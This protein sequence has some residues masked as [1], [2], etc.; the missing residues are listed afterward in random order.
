MV[1]Q[2]LCAPNELSLVS[3]KILDPGPVPEAT[4]P[5]PPFLPHVR[6]DLGES[7]ERRLQSLARREAWP[8]HKPL[9]LLPPPAAL[10]DPGS[11]TSGP[12][13]PHPLALEAMAWYLSPDFLVYK[14]RR[15]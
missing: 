9:P 7:G 13:P 14:T 8:W 6:Q 15:A 11:F 10:P 2:V 5:L 1:S 12:P 4:Y 3:E